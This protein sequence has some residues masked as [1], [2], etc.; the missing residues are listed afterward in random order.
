MLEGNNTPE[1]KQLPAR[2]QQQ[3]PEGNSTRKNTRRIDRHISVR[4]DTTRIEHDKLPTCSFSDV[5]KEVMKKG[6]IK[7]R[8]PENSYVP[9]CRKFGQHFVPL[10][11]HLRTF[12]G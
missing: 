3:K 2:R 7:Y 4:H 1:R 11:K 12:T 9:G 8:R 6:Y 10:T 5:K